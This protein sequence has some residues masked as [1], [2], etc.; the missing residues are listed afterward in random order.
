[1]EPVEAAW[2]EAGGLLP[3]RG[4]NEADPNGRIRPLRFPAKK[5]NSITRAFLGSISANASSASSMAINSRS[6][7]VETSGIWSRLTAVE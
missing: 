7:P 1:V 4:V 2:S 6:R 5:R 3:G